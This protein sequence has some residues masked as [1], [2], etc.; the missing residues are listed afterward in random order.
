MPVLNTVGGSFLPSVMA[1]GGY[2]DAK[3]A[4][5]NALG[6]V[7]GGIFL[8]VLYFVLG[9]KLLRPPRLSGTWVLES[10]ISHTKYNPF[11]GMVLRYKILLLQDGTKLHGTAEKVYEESDKV[12]TF[13]GINRTTAILDGTVEK[14]YL[15]R[16]TIFLHVVEKGEQRSSSWVMEARC[17]RFSR[18][19]HLTGRFSGTASDASGIVALERIPLPNRV[20]E[21]RGLPL[22]WFSRLIRIITALAYGNEWNELRGEI[23]NLA[24]RAKEF[25]ET[26][27]SHLLVAALVLAED[28]RF[29]SHG[30]TDP[31]AICRA[32]FSTIV[33][34]KVQGGSTIEQQL[35]RRLTSDYRKSVKRKLKEIALAVRLHGVLRKDQIAVVYLVSAYYGWHMNGLGQAAQ[36][37]SIDLKDPTVQEAAHLIT[38]I[39]YPEPR[40]PSAHLSIAI[41]KRQE[42]I[43]REL[44]ARTYLLY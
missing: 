5:A 10:V 7:A 40:H 22:D 12:R 18:R 37:L 33:Q 27:N 30:G 14:M 17:R 42:W 1:A 43:A 3:A 44:Q 35:V 20:D 15:G 39:R 29:Y 38:R 19:M 8:T 9:Q 32:L 4:L 21:Y 34:N 24:I 41:A 11:R 26:H 16:S 13:T 23:A 36:R 2:V 25:W 28:R 6:T 31:I